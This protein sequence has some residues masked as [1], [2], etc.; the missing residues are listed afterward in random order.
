MAACSM[1]TCPLSGG[2]GVKSNTAGWV[3]S[4]RSKASLR[5]LGQSLPLEIWQALP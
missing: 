1:L 3:S 4:V 2:K 5:I